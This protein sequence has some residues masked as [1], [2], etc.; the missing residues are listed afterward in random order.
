MP[1]RANF[2]DAIFQ[3]SNIIKCKNCGLLQINKK[4]T[5]ETI[6]DYYKYTYDREKMYN[7]HLDQFPYDNK[8]SV[9]RG[10]ALA[11]LLKQQNLDKKQDS[12]VMDLGCGYGHLLYGF[13][14][15]FQNQYRV[16]GVDYDEKVKPIS[17]KNNWKFIPGGIDDVYKD[18]A[19]KIDILIT[20]HV[21]EH[22]INPPDFLNKCSLL[23]VQDGILLW[24]MPNLNAYNLECE[25]RHS[26]HICLW[27]IHSINEILL[28]NDFEIVFLETAGKKYKW[29]DRK[30]PLPLFLN[31]VYNKLTRNEE[32]FEL[33][34]RNSIG[35]ELDKY[36]VNRRN[37]RLIARKKH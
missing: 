34:D 10:R 11:K 6:E 37:I 3:N 1:Y 16:I 33:N 4:F 36:G 14:N 25:P 9:S 23:L 32:T 15:Y 26:P 24:E 30:K 18:Y 7:F 5:P 35:F 28:R 12:V 20:S 27:D 8:W 17:D 19:G 22:V 13:K 2:S 29:L 31:K 21:F